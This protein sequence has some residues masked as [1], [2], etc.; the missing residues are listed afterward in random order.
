M[1]G[2]RGRSGPPGPPEDPLEHLEESGPRP[3]YALDGDE[4]VLVDEAVKLIREKALSPKAAA[5][6]L[7]VISASKGSATR[8]VEAAQMLPAF[9]PTRLVIVRDAEKITG[10]DADTLIPYVQSPSP[11]TVL[12]LLA[13]AKP[14]DGKTKLYGALKKAGAAIRFSHPKQGEMFGIIKRRARMAGI[15]VDEGAVRA[16]VAALG[17]NVGGTIAA[18]EMLALYVGPGAKKTVTAADVEAVVSPAK[19]ESIF[20]LCD[21]VGNGNKGKA[22]AQMKS[23]LAPRPGMSVEG[24]SLG[25]LAMISRH[26]RTLLAARAL[27]SVDASP[28]S[29]KEA[30][31]SV[32]SF[33]LDDT[34]RQARRYRTAALV[35]GIQS[36]AHA[37]RALKGGGLDAERVMEKLVLDLSRP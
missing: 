1:P 10:D 7:D 32:P 36:I 9:A 4:R 20:E 26:W 13:D 6:N 33:K 28:A 15:G 34:V 14:F 19:E 18:L 23:L 17:T 27:I 8:I 21:A 2:Y 29:L 12:I 16:L 24:L 25:V 30:L 11:T 3:V 22:I 35:R 31:P 37:D 5:F